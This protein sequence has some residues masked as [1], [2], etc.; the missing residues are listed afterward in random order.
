[1]SLFLYLV[2][3][4]FGNLFSKST[5]IWMSI[6]GGAAALFAILY[7]LMLGL[8]IALTPENSDSRTQVTVILI[9]G[10]TSIIAFGVIKD[11]LP[12]YKRRPN[13]IPPNAPVG[14][15]NRWLINQT[16]SL[17]NLFVGAFVLFTISFATISWSSLDG[18][19]WISLFMAV[20]LTSEFCS[21]AI[22]TLFEYHVKY[23]KLF[24]AL[25]LALIGTMIYMFYLYYSTM[26]IWMPWAIT[27][28]WGVL[29][30]GI[31]L[32]VVE[33]RTVRPMHRDIL[34]TDQA[35]MRM[36]FRN[37]VVR[38]MLLLAFVFKIIMGVFLFFSIDQIFATRVIANQI[39]IWQYYLLLLSPVVVFTYVFGNAWVFFREVYLN[40]QRVRPVRFSLFG[41]YLQLV[42][43]PLL[44]DLTLVFFAI[45]IM[46]IRWADAAGLVVMSHLVCVAIG[47]NGSM[48]LPKKVD[49]STT[50]RRSQIHTGVSVALFVALVV[51]TTGY[52]FETTR[53]WSF[54]SSVIFSLVLIYYGL[55][56]SESYLHRI[57][58]LV[59]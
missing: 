1:M 59:T 32:S 42:S 27:I 58:D 50:L 14:L 9:G 12:S 41:T 5:G 10:L 43:L 47:F 20:V 36:V 3:S 49:P 52:A 46:E 2:R 44:I 29:S 56:N 51:F 40:M 19:M 28:A 11:F 6:G 16:T 23:N 35:T 34:N 8:L 13:L 55:R 30:L 45:I 39:I 38:R 7:G 26:S 37:D 15:V 22:R 33:L 57:N 24:F 17:L 54:G 31:D 21:Y 25:T 53:W 48:L 4:R 18:P